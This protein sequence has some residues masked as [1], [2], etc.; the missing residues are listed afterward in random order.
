MIVITSGLW[1]AGSILGII[2]WAISRRAHL[3]AR[4]L[5]ALTLFALGLIY[6][7]LLR[8]SA[9]QIFLLRG[10]QDVIAWGKWLPLIVGPMV[11]LLWPLA[12]GKR[13]WV[14]RLELLLLFAITWL[15]GGIYQVYGKPPSNPGQEQWLTL[16]STSST[17][18]PAALSALLA[19]YNVR[20]TE[21]ELIV[22]CMTTNRGTPLQ[23]PIPSPPTI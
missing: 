10:T 8:D 22:D 18:S 16:Q 17:C 21:G 4:W 20:R 12:K 19:L 3:I 11:G 1:L 7:A 14:L 2:T 15:D 13:K 23:G 5:L 6:L 9:Y